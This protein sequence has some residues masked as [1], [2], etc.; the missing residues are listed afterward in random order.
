MKM[1][2]AGCFLAYA[3]EHAV[4]VIGKARYEFRFLFS[5]LF[6]NSPEFVSVR[7][8][9]VLEKRLPFFF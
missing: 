9:E 4:L 8:I 7:S 1:K 6:F 2:L 3:H 5:F